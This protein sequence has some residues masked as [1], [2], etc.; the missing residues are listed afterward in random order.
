MSIDKEMS[1][2]IQ[3]EII[4]T[5]TEMHIVNGIQSRC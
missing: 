4:R 5:G 1:S 3:M 2:A